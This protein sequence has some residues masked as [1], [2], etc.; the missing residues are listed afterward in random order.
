MNLQMKSAEQAMESFFNQVEGLDHLKVKARGDL[1][2][3]VSE[4][5][6]GNIYPHARLRKKSVHKWSLEMPARRGWEATFIQGTERE[7]LEW[8]IEKFPWALSPRC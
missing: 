1:L 6:E 3:I 4:D 2:T 8:L 5:E 7:L